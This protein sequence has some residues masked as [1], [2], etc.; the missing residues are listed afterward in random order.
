M[1]D[2]L[3]YIPW[4]GIESNEVLKVMDSTAG[5]Q[6]GTISP[7]GKVTSPPIVSG[8]KASFVVKLHDGTK[9]GCVHQLP[10]GSLINQFRA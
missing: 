1:S 9:M 2:R 5:I 7:R 4:N 3:Y 10:S 6:A 8:D